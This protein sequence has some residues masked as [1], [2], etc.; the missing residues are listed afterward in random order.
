MQNTISES[1]IY[2]FDK[3]VDSDPTVHENVK[4]LL[5]SSDKFLGNISQPKLETGNYIESQWILVPKRYSSQTQAIESNKKY[6]I[7]SEHPQDYEGISGLLKSFV[8]EPW[9]SFDEKQ[10]IQNLREWENTMLNEYLEH[11]GIGIKEFL[12]E[13]SFSYWKYIEGRNLIMVQDEVSDDKFHFFAWSEGYTGFTHLCSEKWEFIFWNEALFSKTEQS[14]LIKKYKS[15]S[16]LANFDSLQRPNIELQIWENGKI[17]FLQYK[18]GHQKVLYTW[19]LEEKLDSK[20]IPARFV[21]WITPEEW[22]E[23]KM[24]NGFTSKIFYP[25]ETKDIFS[26][27]GDKTKYPH[28]VVICSLEWH[29]ASLHWLTAYITQSWLHINIKN[30]DLDEDS[31]KLID[32][33]KYLKRNLERF[34]I[35]NIC[36]INIKV[37]SDG[38]IWKILILS[39]LKD[40]LNKIKVSLDNEKDERKK[41]K[42]KRLVWEWVTRKY[43]DQEL[44]YDWEFNLYEIDADINK[45]GITYWLWN[46][47]KHMEIQFEKKVTIDDIKKYLSDTWII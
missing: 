40:F 1:W 38:R 45:Y 35:N 26:W 15:I 6:I 20:E 36:D 28:A 14:Q 43:Y 42:I 32:L 10:Y 33:M 9:E 18:R 19:K 13:L 12:S 21:R 47:L 23:V 3:K 4:L 37:Y 22:I 41:V 30:A 8:I 39:T 44:L 25:L 11:H 46:E 2:T 31:R 29:K 24:I 16:W 17:Y 5:E 27:L 7:R 34:N